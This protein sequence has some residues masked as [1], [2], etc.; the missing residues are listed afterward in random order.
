VIWSAVG[1]GGKGGLKEVPHIVTLAK[2]Y[3]NFVGIY[4]DDFIVDAKKMPDGRLVGKP[5]MSREE[6]AQMRNL[7]K[8][9]ARPMDIWSTLYAHELIP[10]HPN[11]RVCEPPL[12]DLLDLFDVLTLWTWNSDELPSLE[13]SLTA[14]E[15]IA[16]KKARKLLGLYVWDYFNRKPVPVEMMRFQCEQGLTWLKEGRIDG[17]IFLS[18]SSLDVGLD[19][20]EFAREWIARVKNYTLG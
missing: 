20:A 2:K 10:S 11:Y 3:P 8:E 18:N 4:L 14:L 19:S 16:P 9:V 5:A 17:M 12:S 1:S 7:L 6:F 15:S 13:Q